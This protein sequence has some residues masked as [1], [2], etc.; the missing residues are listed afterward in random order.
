MV[1]P[2]MNTLSA[3]EKAEVTNTTSQFTKKKSGFI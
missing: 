3:E 2:D 1:K